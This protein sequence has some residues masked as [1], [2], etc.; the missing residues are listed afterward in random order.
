MSDQYPEKIEITAA[1]E[2]VV[3]CP[4]GCI[5]LTVNRPTTVKTSDIPWQLAG[6]TDKLILKR[7][8]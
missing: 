5:H 1:G 6:A 7:V 8:R 2:W 4:R 3:S